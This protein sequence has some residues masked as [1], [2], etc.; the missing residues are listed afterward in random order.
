VFHVP[1]VVTKINNRY[2]ALIND[3][4]SSGTY[5]V[6]WNPKDFDDTKTHWAKADINNIAARLELAGTGNN[7]WSPDRNIN[8]SEFAA[9]ISLGLGLMRQDVQQNQFHDVSSSAW[10]HDAVNIANEYGIVLGYEDGAFR[11]EQQIT[12]EQGIAMVARA[13]NLVEPQK[14]I[15]QSEIDALLSAFGDANEVSSW[16]KETAALMVAVG[17]VEGKDGKLLKSQ[18]FMTR[19]ETAAL[20]QRLLK[21]TQL[22]D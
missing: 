6:I 12:R 8:R 17:I 20:I 13:F 5:S 1:T 3:L 16:A 9:M 14:A 4:H 18:D 7:T 2:F 21:K 10:Y 19:A 22:I 15:S 11:G